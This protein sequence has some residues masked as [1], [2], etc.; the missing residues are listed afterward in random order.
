MKNQKESVIDRI[1]RLYTELFLV[2][3]HKRIHSY[4]ALPPADNHQ[5][6]GGTL[7]KLIDEIIKEVSRNYS[8]DD[9]KKMKFDGIISSSPSDNTDKVQYHSSNISSMTLNGLSLYLQDHHAQESHSN[10]SE[11]LQRCVWDHV[12]SAHRFALLG[13]SNT[14]KL[15]ADIACNAIKTLS[16]Y[17]PAKKYSEFYDEI[18]SQITIDKSQKSRKLAQ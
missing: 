14:A 10:L 2:A 7:H 1:R 18:N 9:Y 4:R 8:T 6:I 13:D 11:K 17:M 3:L 16:S 15:H 5:E 12:H